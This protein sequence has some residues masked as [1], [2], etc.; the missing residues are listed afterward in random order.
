MAIA[1]A[2]GMGVGGHRRP[3][4]EDAP[5]VSRARAS[6]PAGCRTPPPRGTRHP[7]EGAAPS[8]SQCATASAQRSCIGTRRW[9]PPLPNTWTVRAS[10]SM[11]STSRRTARPPAARIRTATRAPRRPPDPSL[12]DATGSAVVTGG[13]G[14]IED[15]RQL[16]P[17]E[18]TG[19]ARPPRWARSAS[20]RVGGELTAAVHPREV[21]PQ[22]GGFARDGGAGVAT[23]CQICEVAPQHHAVDFFWPVDGAAFGPLDERADVAHIGAQRGRGAPTEEPRERLEFPAHG[24]KL[25]VYARTGAI[26][27]NESKGG[28]MSEG[29][30]R[31]SFL[32]R[33]LLTAAAGVAGGSVLDACS[34]GTS[35]R[36]H[37]RTP[38]RGDECDA[39]RGGALKFAVEAEE[40]GFDPA[41]ARFDE[42]GVLYARTVF[43]P[44]T[45]I[46]ADG[47]NSALFGEVCDAQRGLLAVD[48]H[49]PARR[50]LPRRHDLRRGG[51]CR[52]H[53]A[54]SLRLA[55]R[56]V[57]P[58]AKRQG[59]HPDTVVI[60]LRQP[61][62]PFDAYL[63]GGIGGQAGYIVAP[64]MIAN[65]N[66]SKQPVGTGP[67]KF[68]RVGRRTTTS[69][70][71]AIPNYWRPGMP[72][73]DSITYYP[74]V[75]PESRA[76]CVDG[77]HRQH[78][79]HRRPAGASSSSAP[80]PTT[81]MSTTRKNTLGEP[82]MNF[83]MVNMAVPPM[84]DIR[85]RQAM[86]MAISS[87]QYCDRRR[88]GRQRTVQP[89]VRAGLEV[90]R[91]R[92]R[93]PGLQPR[94]SQ[95]P[96]RSRWRVTRASRWHSP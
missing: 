44:L 46:A 85:V 70:R 88:Q 6:H 60:S 53:R 1:V 75:D 71:R 20:G 61:W 76:E 10:S 18:H 37:R 38:K 73:L 84:N 64:S 92:Q 5:Y 11:S 25:P 24:A 28:C 49:G 54:L 65:P 4:V 78:D 81:A 41:T 33:G 19:Q 7:H 22:R 17:V 43:D 55:R 86:A 14:V 15:L 32:A 21:R 56:H 47:I 29:L 12:A 42:S 95:S 83:I 45:I 50:Y 58:G 89:T 91:A 67:F 27:R 77:R 96:R 30:D 72:Y 59:A 94:A 34:S 36:A 93:V 68:S 62:V 82:D 74:I 13:L 31:R 52:E 66:G 3:A 90:L 80:T 69:P 79:A 87:K 35:E 23:R 8:P 48:D 2:Q 51:H 57:E 39:A 9:R 63:A 16:S 26:V 40:Q